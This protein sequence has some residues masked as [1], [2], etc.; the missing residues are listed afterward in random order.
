MEG[1]LKQ[2]WKKKREK[3]RRVKGVGMGRV[4]KWNRKARVMYV[5]CRTGKGNIQAWTW[6]DID[7]RKRWARKEKDAE[8]FYTVDLVET[9]FSNLYLR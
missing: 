2:R 4:V 1:G 5:Q 7:G 6:E 8:G 9:F 3:E